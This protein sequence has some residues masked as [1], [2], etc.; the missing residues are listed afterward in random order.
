[1]HDT[2]H[3]QP[4]IKNK[5]FCEPGGQTD[6]LKLFR[7][8]LMPHKSVVPT[9]LTRQWVRGSANTVLHLYRKLPSIVFAPPFHQK[10]AAQ[11]PVAAFCRACIRPVGR[12]V[13]TALRQ[14]RT[15]PVAPG[16][17]AAAGAP[18][19]LGTGSSSTEPS[20]T[21]PVPVRERWGGGWG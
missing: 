4:I 3:T 20:V 16:A 17:T 11:N 10:A 21:C 13:L 12:P 2:H 6:R 15:L 18:T 8:V 9:S 5:V 1:M 19:T 7:W 14:P